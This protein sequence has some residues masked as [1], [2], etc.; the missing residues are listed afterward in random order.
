M[1]FSFQISLFMNSFTF[2]KNCVFRTSFLSRMPAEYHRN[3]YDCR[4]N[5]NLAKPHIFCYN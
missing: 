3:K 2:I 5:P 4:E 1:L